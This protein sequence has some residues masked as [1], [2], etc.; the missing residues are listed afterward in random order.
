MIKI[1]GKN[2]VYEAIFAKAKMEVFIEDTQ[3]KKDK[4]ILS[5]LQDKGFKYTLLSKKD[6]DKKFGTSHQGYGALREDYQILDESFLNTYKKE[7]G[8]V[9]V[10]DGIQDPHNL[11]ARH[12][13]RYVARS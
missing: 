5:L 9:L 7:K 1:Y 4:N 3:A 11:G 2:C 12:N 10:L 8:R 6:M 13:K